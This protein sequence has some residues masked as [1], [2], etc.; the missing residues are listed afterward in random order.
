M[1]TFTQFIVEQEEQINIEEFP[2][3][4]DDIISCETQGLGPCSTPEGIAH[5]QQVRKSA[6][7]LKIVKISGYGSDW[8]KSKV[9]G[10]FIYEVTIKYIEKA[11]DEIPDERLTQRPYFAK[12]DERT[13]NNQ[14]IIGVSKEGKSSV[15]A[16]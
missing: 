1:K 6:E 12:P 16:N 11:N 3:E 9:E 5:V 14:M 8:K 10:D 15:F 13:F 7:I 2:F 4:L